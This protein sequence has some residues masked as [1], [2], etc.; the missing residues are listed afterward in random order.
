MFFFHDEKARCTK[1]HDDE[2]SEGSSSY[3]RRGM[4]PMKFQMVWM[5][6]ACTSMIE[7]S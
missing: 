7:N 6:R 1:M 4:S 2:G 5:A 3:F